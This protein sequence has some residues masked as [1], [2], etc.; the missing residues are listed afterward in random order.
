MDNP[1]TN[2]DFDRDIS[3][4]L[5]LELGGIGDVI[6]SVPAILALRNRFQSAKMTVLTVPRSEDVLIR[7]TTTDLERRADGHGGFRLEVLDPESGILG[8]GGALSLFR[9]LRSQSFDLLVDLSAIES[10]LADLRRWGAVRFIRAGRSIGRGTDG[11]GSCFDRSAEEILISTEHEMERKL[12]VTDLLGARS[13]VSAPIFPV[14]EHEWEETSRFLDMFHVR[15]DRLL[16]AV[17]AGGLASGKRWPARYFRE[18]IGWLTDN[19][20]AAVMVIGGPDC[21]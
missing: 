6:L 20:G 15:E 17:F 2:L 5:I 7:F 13:P 11:R 9:R 10:D 18:A 16:A 4:I 14:L 8:P 12:A 3:K 21:G 1:N 19:L